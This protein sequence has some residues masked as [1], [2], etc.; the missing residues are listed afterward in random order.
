MR[1]TAR[2]GVQEAISRAVVHSPP[3]RAKGTPRLAHG[4]KA[5]ALFAGLVEGLAEAICENA[6]AGGE[7]MMAHLVAE[8]LISRV[9]ANGCAGSC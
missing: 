3:K 4:H 2:E 6:A 8:M 1:S 5:Q 9:H 7:V